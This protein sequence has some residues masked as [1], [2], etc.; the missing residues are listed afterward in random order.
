LNGTTS[1]RH[2]TLARHSFSGTNPRLLLR[3]KLRSQ[4]TFS[5]AINRRGLSR[6]E[7]LI[8]SKTVVR[9]SRCCSRSTDSFSQ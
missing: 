2:F 6:P 1:R 9:Q 3:T 5:S 7:Q 4:G 8:S